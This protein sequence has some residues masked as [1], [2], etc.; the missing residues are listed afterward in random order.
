MYRMTVS[1]GNTISRHPTDFV[2]QLSLHCAEN[3]RSYISGNQ[4]R[5]WYRRTAS[6]ATLLSSVMVQACHTQLL[7]EDGKDSVSTVIA[8]PLMKG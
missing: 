5:R 1:S 3:H 6:D 7:K 2:I 4:A 8:I